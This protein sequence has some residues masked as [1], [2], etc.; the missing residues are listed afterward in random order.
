MLQIVEIIVLLLLLGALWT[1]V[2]LAS[3]LAKALSQVAGVLESAALNI[4]RLAEEVSSLVSEAEDDVEKFGSLLDSAQAV[5]S[6]MNS[7]SRLAY[8]AVALPVVKV[9]A[10]GAGI[11]GLLGVLRSD[12]KS[13]KGR[14]R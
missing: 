9:R 6:S 14:R 11:R 4:S 7:A 3:R 10:A 12:G 8:G 2:V 5:T 1:A 13:S